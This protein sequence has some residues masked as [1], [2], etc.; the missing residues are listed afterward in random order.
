[1]NIKE[2][3]R[4]WFKPRFAVLY[5]FGIF[6]FLFANCDDSSLK[7][8][9]WFMIAGELIRLWANGYA[10][11][12]EKL[13]VSGPYSIIRHPLYLGT[14]LITAG[15]I[16]FLK[17]YYLGLTLLAVMAIVYAGTIKKEEGMLAERFKEYADYRKRVPAFVPTIFPYRDGEKWSFSFKRLIQSQEYKPLLWLAVLV[18][19]FYLK[20]E[21]FVEK[22]GIDAGNL[23]LIIAACSLG[24]IDIA[25]EIM[26]W[27]KRRQ[28]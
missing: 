3:F 23:R 9:I 1:M 19:L 17:I 25:G 18:M 10:I 28:G 5:P 7:A 2:R 26:K 21:F 11:K 16:I 4:R 14:L 12:S 22:K 20:K 24:M 8:G 15:F 6:M 13:T 27:R